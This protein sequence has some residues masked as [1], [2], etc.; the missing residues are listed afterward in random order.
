[1]GGTPPQMGGDFSDFSRWG[2]YPHPPP[3]EKT[4]TTIS[5][6][7]HHQIHS[8]IKHTLR[9]SVSIDFS[10]CQVHFPEKS[11]KK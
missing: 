3:L 10:G 2:E 9:F 7:L 11:K 8:E 4:L 5:K 6:I 1:M